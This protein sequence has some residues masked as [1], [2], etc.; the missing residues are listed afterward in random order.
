M[1]TPPANSN[2][3]DDFTTVFLSE[4]EDI[5]LRREKIQ[6]LREDTHGSEETEIDKEIRRIKDRREGQEK[7]VKAKNAAGLKEEPVREDDQTKKEPPEHH[8]NGDRD[9][10]GLYSVL[11]STQAGLMGLTLSGGGIRSATFNLGL[12][13][14]ICNND[15]LEKVDYISTVSGGGYIGTCMTTLLNSP[16]DDDRKKQEK[17]DD[18]ASIG[19]AADTFPLGR[20]KIKDSEDHALEKDPVRRLR[21]FSNYLTA[22]GGIVAKYLRPAMVFVRGVVLNFSLIAPYIGILGLLLALVFNFTILIPGSNNNPI[23]FDFREFA[24]ILEKSTTDYNQAK[25]NLRRYAVKQTADLNFD[26]DQQR[27]AWVEGMNGSDAKLEDLKAQIKSAK[28]PLQ[29]EWYTIWKLP[30]AFFI[31]MIATAMLYRVFYRH[32]YKGRYGFSKFLA[33]LFFISLVLVIVQL[34]GILIVYWKSWEITAWIA[35][36]SLLSLIG[37]KLLQAGSGNAGS[38]K[39]MLIK[40]SLAF[41]LLLL[42]PLFILYLVGGIIAHISLPNDN[43]YLLVGLLVGSPV[44]WFLNRQFV[45]L[46]EISLHNY[47]RDCLSRAYMMWYDQ[48]PNN[49]THKDDLKFSDLNPE[50]SPYHIVNTTLNIKKK[51][52][53]NNGSGHFRTGESFIFTRNW[54]GTAKTGYVKT[55]QYEKVDPHIDLGTAMAISGAAANIGMAQ[56]NIFILRL[57]MGLLNIRLGYWALHPYKAR[58][59][60]KVSIWRKFPGSIE[61][62][63]EWF[64]LYRLDPDSRYINL[65]DGGHFDNIGVYELLRR[66]CKY[67][68]VGDAEADSEMKFE[69]LSYIMR[70]ARI[71]FGIEIRINTSDIKPDPTTGY[72]RNHCA[73]GRIDYPE[74]DFGY[75]LYCK[76]SLTGD[77]PE[78]LNEYKVKHPQYPHQTTA[79]QWFDEQQFE[80]YRELGYHI[81]KEA[82]APLKSAAGLDTE[83][84]F[85]LLK[86]YWYPHSKAVEASFTKHAAELNKIVLEIKNDE[87]FKFMDFHMYPEWIHLIPKSDDSEPES[88]SDKDSDPKS[89]ITAGYNLW[90]PTD[91][92]EIRKGFYLCNLMMQLMENV[93]TDLNL[94]GEYNHPDNRGWMNL[95]RHW[96]WSGMFRVAW[97]ISACTFGTRFQKFCER[98]L[99]L[100]LGELSVEEEK[101][102]K[103][104]IKN[105]LNPYEQKIMNNFVNNEDYL[106][107]RIFLLKLKVE[108]PINTD[109]YKTFH[110]G[111]A[112][113]NAHNKLIYFRVQD[114]LRM[115]GLGRRALKKIKERHSIHKYC[116]DVAKEIMELPPKT[117]AIPLDPKNLEGFER[118]CNRLGI[119][120]ETQC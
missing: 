74:G 77:E 103:A 26:S 1:T 91:P 75:L 114:H 51:M 105:E 37:P 2:H 50:K 80:A 111:F 69:A 40:I 82:L 95:F 107:K 67:I 97:T 28:E 6:S 93:Y 25:D 78:H 10:Y 112:L 61:A 8:L 36:A 19:L 44:L 15:M 43:N 33:K 60:L 27:I 120:V 79:D 68:I 119:E 14:A 106:L 48:P 90:L 100:K 4:L 12:L 89:D 102:I 9:R 22:E 101:P 39:K 34:Y 3:T 35:S 117:D 118:M 21:Y 96:S 5:Q 88:D 116:P 98:H 65:S 66:R 24:A 54:C 16:T 73:V 62:F 113:V 13:Q 104:A 110:F 29:K 11:P 20:R 56:K 108:N 52:P 47:Y 38:G 23:F 109:D 32:A 64:G 17:I 45:N 76:A 53:D 55:K 115:M 58:S 49:L 70:M 81:G 72:S 87:D 46:N 30:G 7:S 57:L 59:K 86:E 85:N 83:E 94:E 84:Q 99:D 42:V 63:Q 31:F 18:H 41:L 71:D 92:K